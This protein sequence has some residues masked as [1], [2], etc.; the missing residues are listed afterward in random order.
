MFPDLTFELQS[1]ESDV[2]LELIPSF[3]LVLK[4]VG[5]SHY[6]EQ[7]D[8]QAP[9]IRLKVVWLL[10]DKLRGHERKRATLLLNELSVL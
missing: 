2:L 10:Q 4:W 9:D 7:Y 5:A 3:S 6:A 8:A 1:L